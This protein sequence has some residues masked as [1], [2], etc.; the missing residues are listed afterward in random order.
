MAK[1]QYSGT[2]MS[3]YVLQAKHRDATDEFCGLLREGESLRDVMQ[4]AIDASAPYLGRSG[5]YPLEERRT[6]AGEL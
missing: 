1:K 3:G 2:T 5:A 4:Q 6:G